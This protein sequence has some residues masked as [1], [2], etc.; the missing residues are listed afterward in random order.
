MVEHGIGTL[1]IKKRGVE[2]DPAELRR[3]L[4][5]AGPHQATM[6]ISRTPHGAVAVIA[7]RVEAEST[8]TNLT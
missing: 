1:E 7:S 8:E 4:R 2:L 3:Q 5:L 6:I